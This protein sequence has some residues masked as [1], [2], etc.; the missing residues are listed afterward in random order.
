[1]GSF[2]GPLLHTLIHTDGV[3]DL[4]C[5]RSCILDI[6]I[7]TDDV[8]LRTAGVPDPYCT[9]AS[10]LIVYLALN[11]LQRAAHSPRTA[12]SFYR[13]LHSFKLVKGENDE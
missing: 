10:K 3:I 9:L 7:R 5:T 6:H 1:M 13:V 2:G 11:T 8:L 4:C 12:H